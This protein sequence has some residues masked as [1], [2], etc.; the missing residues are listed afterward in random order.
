VTAI[1]AG[2]AI[3]AAISREGQLLS[4]GRNGVSQLGLSSTD[5]V[6][7]PTRAKLPRGARATRVDAGYHHMV[8]LADSGDLFTFG[9]DAKG[10]PLPGT[11]TLEHGWGHVRMVRAG[12]TFTLA[13]TSRGLLLAWGSNSASQLGTGDLEDR[14]MPVVV[15]FP[16]R[17]GPVTDFWAG[18]YSAVALTSNHE[19]YTWG[20]TRFG[21][22]G[23]GRT[24]RPQTRP[25]RITALDGSHLNRVH[26]GASHVIV[27]T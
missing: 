19:I 9:A 18:T 15:E 16:D 24:A 26:G 7:V 12:E 17:A 14:V 20:E 2:N 23:N 8:V 4:W 1:G 10:K 25:A 22:G 5:D 21:Q 13:L 3:S 11:V 27:T 6:A